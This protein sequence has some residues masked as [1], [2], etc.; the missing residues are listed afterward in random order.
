[1]NLQLKLG[2]Q[3]TF[4]V[5]AREAQTYLED[6]Y[7]SDE[8]PSVREFADVRGVSGPK[9]RAETIRTLHP[10]KTA[11]TPAVDAADE[12]VEDFKH[13]AVLSIEKE[14]RECRGELSD[15]TNPLAQCRKRCRIERLKSEKASV[16]GRLGQLLQ[17]IDNGAQLDA[18][19]M[20]FLLNREDIDSSTKQISTIPT[21][22]EKYGASVSRSSRSVF[23]H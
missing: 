17:K 18:Q 19:E 16:N 9:T 21:T 22:D 11:T 4:L 8:L 23:G 3:D 13:P 20:S 14:I 6:H 12:L 2:R 10:K 5:D 15:E 1:M 7:N